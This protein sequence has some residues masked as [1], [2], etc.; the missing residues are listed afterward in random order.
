MSA[1]R[2]IALSVYHRLPTPMRS[3]A[4]TLRGASLRRWR[5]GQETERLVQEALARE[6]W[7]PHQWARWREDRLARL[8][9]RAATSVP[10]YRDM[11]ARRRARGDRRSVEL[12]AHWPILR[13]DT[14]RA[15]PEQFVADDCHRAR[16]F[17][18]H[19]S[20]TSGKALDLWWSRATVRD[21]YALFEARCRLWYGVSRHDRWA[22]LGGQL[23]VPASQTAPPFWVWNA[24]LNQLYMSTYHLST[25]AIA[26]YIEALE[27]HRVTYLWGYSS[28]LYELAA[29]ILRSKAASRPSLKVVIT[30]AEPLL[31]YQRA[32]IEQ[33]FGCP[34]RETY[35]MAEIVAAASECGEGHLHQWPEVGLIELR[36]DNESV[37][38]GAAG[39][40]V[41]TGLLNTD[42]PLIRYA[43]GDRLAMAPLHASPCGCGRGL[44][45]VQG[46]EGRADDLLVTRD[47]RRIGRMD[48]V[49]K[50]GLPI[51]EAQIIQEALDRLR[52]RYVPDPA[53]CAATEHALREAVQA[54]VGDMEVVMEKVA[55]I[56]RTANGKFRAVVSELPAHQRRPVL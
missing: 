50:A 26:S 8:L 48:P 18:E 46:I 16:M 28:A 1:M 5:Y 37:R 21:W 13:K 20:G 44:P 36:E 34:V 15:A 2:R 54:R 25:S 42:M 27:Q 19:T 41:A 33:A 14:L 3:V 49:F 40:V 12:L 30:N 11:W 55:R 7:T 47:G 10:H 38:P 9:H 23:V 45:V 52:I 56:P 24:A 17:H 35:G 29:G 43:V 22:I 53:F 32:A 31:P 39:E 4:A 51:A 6:S